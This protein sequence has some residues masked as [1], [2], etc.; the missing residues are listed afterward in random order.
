[1]PGI[2]CQHFK[3]RRFLHK[4]WV[5]SLFE[6]WDCLKILHPSASHNSA[7][8]C[9]SGVVIWA[10]V[11]PPSFIALLCTEGIWSVKASTLMLGWCDSVWPNPCYV[12][13]GVENLGSC[14]LV[15]R[16]AWFWSRKIFFCTVN[17]EV[18]GA[19]LFLRMQLWPLLDPGRALRQAG[20][21]IHALQPA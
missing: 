11:F 10:L 20:R 3:I 18:C 13:C 9:F 16:C 14:T 8:S 12:L 2:C 21:K 7:V 15:L 5:L 17:E 6:S 19:R 1:M 4:V